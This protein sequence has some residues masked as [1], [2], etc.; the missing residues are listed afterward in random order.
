ML[1]PLGNESGLIIEMYA[2]EKKQSP[3][4]L[5]ELAQKIALILFIEFVIFGIFILTDPGFLKS[6]LMYFIIIVIISIVI[7]IEVHFHVLKIEISVIPSPRFS[8][9]HKKFELKNK[10]KLVMFLNVHF[11]LIAVI[12]SIIDIFTALSRDF[13]IIQSF[14]AFHAWLERL[15]W[16]AGIASAFIIL[17]LLLNFVVNKRKI[18][19]IELIGFVFSIMIVVYINYFRPTNWDYGIFLNFKKYVLALSA[20]YGLIIFITTI[21]Q[22]YFMFTVE[23]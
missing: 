17:T 20:C 7:T 21:F 8:R 18:A 16:C 4:Q 23:V 9:K 11:S 12:L 2:K 10:D 3:M 19:L 15:S 1:N 6:L 14:S 13:V 22:E 5:R